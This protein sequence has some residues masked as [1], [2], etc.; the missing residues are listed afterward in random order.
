MTLLLRNIVPIVAGI[1]F[2]LFLAYVSA[3]WYFSDQIITLQAVPID[4]T[5]ANA[6]NESA[7]EDYRDLDRFTPAFDTPAPETGELV[8]NDVTLVYDFYANENFADCA[9]VYAHGLSGDRHSVGLYGPMF[10]DLGCNILAY[11]ARAHNDSDEA[12]LTYGYYERFEALAMVELAA[13]RSDIPVAQVGAVGISYGGATVLQMLAESQDLA[14]VVSDSAFQ[15]ME[16]IVSEQARAVFGDLIN[17]VTPG[18]LA[19]SG[20]R[21]E[22]A[23]NAA[24]SVEAIRDNNVPVLLLHAE[25]DSYVRPTHAQAIYAASNVEQTRLIYQDYGSVH[26]ESIV[27]NPD[28][29]RETVYSFLADYVPAFG[30]QSE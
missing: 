9:V 7:D 1:F 13:T 24:S 6:P 17:I 16:T 25:D 29:I 8:V 23:F 28:G 4:E 21:G 5:I 26:A 20:V 15:D 22:F 18:A 30:A 11:D 10:Y 19:I 12:Y 2:V 3:A 14:F 27:D